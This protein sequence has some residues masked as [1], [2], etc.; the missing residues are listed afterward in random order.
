MTYG[1]WWRLWCLRGKSSRGPRT[2]AIVK[3]L[4]VVSEWATCLT[5][6]GFV[7]RLA[8]D[9]VVPTGQKNPAGKA[10]FRPG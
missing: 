4:V 8:L 3:E 7:V 9:V 1:Y 6:E 5:T 10:S 2:L